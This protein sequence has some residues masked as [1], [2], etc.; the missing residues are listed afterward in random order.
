MLQLQALFLVKLLGALIAIQ[1]Y[2]F[3]KFFSNSLIFLMAA[4]Q[5]PSIVAFLDISG[6]Q[7]S[8]YVQMVI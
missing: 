2:A 6:F 4:N 3:M 8:P 7:D 5:V 1:T